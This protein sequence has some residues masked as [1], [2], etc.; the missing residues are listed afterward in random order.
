MRHAQSFQLD[1]VSDKY[2]DGLLLL[3]DIKFH[4]GRF[5]PRM[6]K[7]VNDITSLKLGWFFVCCSR[8]DLIP[9]LFVRLEV[10]TGIVVPTAILDLVDLIVQDHVES[11]WLLR[12]LHHRARELL[13]K[14]TVLVDFDN[15][16]AI[17]LL[18]LK[19][20]DQFLFFHVFKDKGLLSRP[21]LRN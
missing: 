19:L 9:V 11:D 6:I 5:V 3:T 2:V 17:L 13:V 1:I 20:E 18:M 12:K 15:T 10:H 4:L 21:N 7:V 8:G 14:V 16:F